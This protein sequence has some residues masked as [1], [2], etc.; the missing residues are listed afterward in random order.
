MLPI[1]KSKD[2]IEHIK[3][4]LRRTGHLKEVKSQLFEFITEVQELYSS[5][6]QK[7]HKEM[8]AFEEK[9][10]KN[11][12]YSTEKTNYIINFAKIYR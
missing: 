8:I 9:I 1:E 11:S 5:F 10:V 7:I 6:S 3:S 12:L 2:L 4:L